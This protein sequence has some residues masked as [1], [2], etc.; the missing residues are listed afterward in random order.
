MYLRA[1]DADAYVAKVSL[2]NS[3]AGLCGIALG[4]AIAGATG[5]AIGAMVQQIALLCAL[6]P[7]LRSVHA[8]LPKT[9]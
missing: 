4:A 7:R 3:A 6:A 1:H 2:L 9:T 5:A 8:R